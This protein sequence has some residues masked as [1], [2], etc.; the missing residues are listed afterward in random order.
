M[1]IGVITV[2]KEE[3]RRGTLLKSSEGYWDNLML[4]AC[5]T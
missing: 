1:A 5:A 2:L 3:V 4:I